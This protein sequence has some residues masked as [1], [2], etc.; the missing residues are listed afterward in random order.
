[1][2]ESSRT[3]ALRGRVPNT[4]MVLA[5]GR[6]TRLAAIPDLPPKPLVQVGGK[7]LI[8]HAIDLLAAAGV[9]R[10]VV[11]THHRAELIDD[12][13]ARRRA[14]AIAV[15]REKALLDPGGGV[16]NASPPLGAEPFW[17]GRGSGRGRGCAYV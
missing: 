8:E 2:D 5:A 13:L 10:I 6:G 1:M 14:P 17:P 11:N 7:A 15:S 4:A 3:A 12:H 9:Q 16:K